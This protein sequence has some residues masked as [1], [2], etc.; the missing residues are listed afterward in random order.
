[1]RYRDRIHY[2]QVLD[3]D[4]VLRKIEKT[5]V[6]LELLQEGLDSY[7]LRYPEAVNYGK[8]LVTNNP[9]VVQQ[10][11]Y[12]ERNI[13]LISRASDVSDIDTSFFKLPLEEPYQNTDSVSSLR[14]LTSIRE[15]LGL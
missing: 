6:I 8:K 5:N 7:T 3:Y 9:Y 1:M 15:N 11:S 12:S 4:V 13:R 10:E 2:N 14:F